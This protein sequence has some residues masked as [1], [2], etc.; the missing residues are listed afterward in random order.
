M[1]TKTT[2]TAWRQGGTCSVAEAHRDMWAWVMRWHHCE[3]ML[4]LNIQ[5][6]DSVINPQCLLLHLCHPNKPPRD[7]VTRQ[8]RL[9]LHPEYL[10]ICFVHHGGYVRV[11]K[12]SLHYLDMIQTGTYI[13]FQGHE[14]WVTKWRKADTVEEKLSSSMQCDNKLQEQKDCSV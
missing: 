4:A 1:G 9:C 6:K 3:S 2:R 8:N 13:K 5:S 7:N 14:F 11:R 10:A 12:A